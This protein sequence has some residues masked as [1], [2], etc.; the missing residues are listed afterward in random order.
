LPNYLEK[1]IAGLR[2]KYRYFVIDHI[3]ET[4]NGAELGTAADSVKDGTTTPFQITVVSSSADDTDSAAKDVRKVAIIGVTVS[5]A[6]AKA[7]NVSNAKLTVEVVN[8]NGTGDVTTSRYYVRLIHAYACHW[9]SAG[10][11]AKGNITIESPANTTLIKIVA[12]SNESN[13]GTL[14]FADGDMVRHDYTFLQPYAT[15][16]AADGFTVSLTYKGFD[17][18]LNQD[19]DMFVDYYTHLATRSVPS[20]QVRPCKLVP[21]LARLNNSILLTGT[22]IANAKNYMCRLGVQ[23]HNNAKRS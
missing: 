14:Y 12:G 16:A 19:A 9:G 20:M 7:L 17:Q 21:E 11:D 23:I 10:A 8:M 13:G 1:P 4:P 6:D 22:L 5:E 2:K 3:G 18:T 15:M